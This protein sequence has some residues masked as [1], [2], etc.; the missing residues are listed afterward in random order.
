MNGKFD[1]LGDRFPGCILNGQSIGG[2]FSGRNIQA[3]GV[4]RPDRAGGRI[5]SDGLGVGNVVAKLSGFA[6]VDGARRD[7][8]PTDGEFGAA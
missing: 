4:G 8:E 1:A 2:G 3:S 5:E 6:V 7:V